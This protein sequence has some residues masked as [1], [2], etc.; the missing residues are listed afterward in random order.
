M[1]DFSKTGTT[2]VFFAS[3]LLGILCARSLHYQFYVWFYHT[4]V[5]L[6]WETWHGLGIELMQK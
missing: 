4:L 3:N 2:S 6:V 1:I 5:W